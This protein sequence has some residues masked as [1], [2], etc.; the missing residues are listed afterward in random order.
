MFLVI[1]LKEKHFLKGNIFKL[2]KYLL[3]HLY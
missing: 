1:K 3:F 2:V